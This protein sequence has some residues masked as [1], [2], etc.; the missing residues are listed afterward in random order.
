MLNLVVLV[1]TGLNMGFEDFGPI[2]MHVRAR[3]STSFAVAPRISSGIR[4]DNNGCTKLA[5]SF[6]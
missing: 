3:S 2:N 6:K 1:L 5:K 4:N